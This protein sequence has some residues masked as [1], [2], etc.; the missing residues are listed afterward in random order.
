MPLKSVQK[1]VQWVCEA[2]ASVVKV[3]VT[4]IDETLVRVAGTGRYAEGI[5]SKL[6]HGSAFQ[7]ALNTGVDFMIDRPGEHEA[8]QSCAC[9]SGCEEEAELCCPIVLEERVVGVIGLIAFDEV[10]RSFLM[11]QSQSLMIFL[12][13][14][15]DLIASKA[16]AEEAI[17]VK[18]LMAE[19]LNLAID[20]SGL[21]F[22]AFDVQGYVKREN[23]KSVKILGSL[24]QKHLSDFL[25]LHYAQR[26]L[27][28]RKSLKQEMMTF[29][30][31]KGMGLC[32]WVPIYV[33]QVLKGFVMMI[34]PLDEVIQSFQAITHDALKTSF[35]DIIGSSDLMMQAK[36][37]AKKVAPQSST[38][39]I[40]GESG[41]GKEL[42]ARAI[43][44]ES[45]RSHKAFISINCAAI[46]ETLLESELFGY[47]EGAFTG[48][49][50]G[51]KPG[52][53]MLASGGT[54]F[55]DEIGDMPLHMQTKLLRV[56]Q[57]RKIS[58]I[59]SVQDVEVD[60]RIIAA[61]HHAMEK[62]VL[63][64]EFR[65]DLYYRLNVIPIHIPPL[66]HRKD[67]LDEMLDLLLER[68][69]MKLQKKI[70]SLCEETVAILKAYHWPGNVR[71]LEN[72]I[73]YA[74]NMC[75]NHCVKPEHLPKR[76][77]EMF[78]ES[79]P[80][81][82]DGNPESV[83]LLSLAVMEK[84][85]IVKALTFYRHE[86][87]AVNKAAKKLGIS[88]ATLYRKIKAYEIDFS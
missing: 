70:T 69:V 45:Q 81:A 39:L 3:D 78:S 27:K 59:G 72:T 53:M 76:L 38:V 12:K 86:S 11:E 16:L 64:G 25:E 42:F 19:E 15:A 73:E 7:Y 71:E 60:V 29:K 44:R 23:T 2:I 5:G 75:D 87:N 18:A 32:D 36:H 43:H 80:S 1:D 79:M 65:Q 33:H 35:D 83:P 20:A 85:M 57:E 31:S 10:Q 34:K 49:Q 6:S 67:D 40:L 9:K 84:E 41:T 56:L 46:P 8:C 13:R 51:G 47:E 54:L 28:A 4:I 37:E 21:A 82:I 77:T 74:V 66:R 30:N 22:L 63:E 55:L 68:C 14:M 61:T 24:S 26:L 50:K 58:P 62:K 17:E 48:A 88:R 52:K